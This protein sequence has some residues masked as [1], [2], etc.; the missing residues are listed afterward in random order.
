VVVCPP[1]IWLYPI[2]EIYEKSPQFLSLGAQNMF[3]K[4]NG[5]FTGEVSPTMLKGMVKYVIIGHSERRYH[6]NESDE[7][8]NDK[9]LSAVEHG[10]IPIL[11]VGERVK[12]KE[13]ESKAEEIEQLE[14]DLQGLSRE[15]MKKLIVAYEPVW[16]IGTGDPATGEYAGRVA[17]NIRGKI[18][19]LYDEKI[20]DDV[21]ILYGGSVT[22]SNIGEFMDECEIDGALVGGASV[23]TDDFVQICKVIAKYR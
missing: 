22:P 13:G 5:A 20:A 17:K 23:K 2:A 18:A 21:P 14:K 3:W 4:E 19:E 10:L 16:A 8:I 11:C 15:K 1:Y 9:V 7:L 12:K 6:F